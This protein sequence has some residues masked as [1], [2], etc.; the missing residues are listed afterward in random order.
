VQDAAI[1]VGEILANR[2]LIN[3]QNSCRKIRVALILDMVME[4]DRMYN[5]TKSKYRFVT[6]S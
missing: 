1:S 3:F 5:Y 4:V 6:K 2:F